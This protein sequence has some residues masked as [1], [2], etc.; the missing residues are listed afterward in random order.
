MPSWSSQHPFRLCRFGPLPSSS[1]LCL[2]SSL[3]CIVKRC[4]APHLSASLARFEA[5]PHQPCSGL[6]HRHL[7]PVA[8]SSAAERLR[9]SA[10]SYSQLD[11]SRSLELNRN[12]SRH[13]HSPFAIQVYRNEK[14]VNSFLA[15]QP[16]F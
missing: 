14:G 1:T 7:Q 15:F 12:G 13:S 11:K 16:W 10:L 2:P 8:R 6:Q 3:L 5:Q 4:F 9:A